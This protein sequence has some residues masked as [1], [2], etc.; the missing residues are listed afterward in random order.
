MQ[1]PVIVLPPQ[2]HHNG[3]NLVCFRIDV[4]KRVSNITASERFYIILVNWNIIAILS[5]SQA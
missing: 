3:K 2:L 4:N 1:H 5:L